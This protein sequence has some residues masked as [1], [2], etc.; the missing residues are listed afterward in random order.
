MKRRDD[1]RGHHPGRDISQRRGDRRDI[2]QRRGDRRSGDWRT[3]AGLLAALPVA[4]AERPADDAAQRRLADFWA[5]H[6]GPAA[7]RSTPLL[8]ASGRLVVFV[9]AAAWGHEIR[10]RAPGLLQELTRN[11]IAAN[12][13]TVK[14]RPPPPPPPPRKTRP[15]F[16]LSPAS[17]AHL[18]S[19][20]ETIDHPPL[21]QALR[22]LAK[23]AT[24]A[25]DE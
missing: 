1:N 24:A 7:A 12:S 16:R 9:D 5:R 4:A 15:P 14:T 18:K 3:V 23:R 20:A 10:H 13:I 6:F 17:A 8:F 25:L 11:G 22:R 19:L 2:R 21:A